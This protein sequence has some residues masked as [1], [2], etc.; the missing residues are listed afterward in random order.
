MPLPTDRA[1]F[2]WIAGGN[3]ER[4][5][6]FDRDP[7]RDQRRG[8]F[9]ALII[10]LIGVSIGGI[11]GPAR[12]DESAAGVSHPLIET[13]NTLA[14]WE[15]HRQAVL[16]RMQGVMGPLPAAPAPDAPAWETLAKTDCGS[17]VRMRIRYRSQPASWTP[18]FLCVPKRVLEDPASPP[19]VAAVLC[20]HPT[21]NVNGHK[22][23]VGLGGRANRQYG[24]ELAERGFVTLS[25]GYPLL[26]DYQPDLQAL[27]WQSGTL[28]AV[29]DN[30]RG[31]DLLQSLPYVDPQG[32]GA[33]G[34][35][36]G[37]HNA[38]YTAVFDRRVQAVV[39]SCGLDSYRDYY[40]GD[41]ARWAR[42]QG[43]TSD[44]YM[45]RLAAYQN[46]LDELPFDFHEMLAALAPRRV[47]VIAPLHD[48][49]FRADSVDRVTATARK[50][51]QLY[52]TPK[53]LQVRHPDCDHDFPWAE[54]QAAYR[55][56]RASLASAPGG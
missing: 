41:P 29:W 51:F 5:P 22:V 27:G 36:L 19:D 48:S 10:L 53:A 56:F 16:Q 30:M 26:A 54:R 6:Q 7:R 34:H 9:E 15:S 3:P 47:L 32:I 40:G 21:D 33:I 31:I 39:S 1:L 17:Y 37:G 4:S 23:V 45:P 28:K 20:L 2:H 55:F 8:W 46:R 49:N 50:I 25:P 14:E 52:G 44:R 13:A 12:A 18:A 35:S 43:W 24:S 11:A 38:V 42:G